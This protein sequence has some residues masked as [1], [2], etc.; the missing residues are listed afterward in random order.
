MKKNFINIL[1]SLLLAM[2]F[3]SSLAESSA[4]SASY[5]AFLPKFE[6]FPVDP[7][8][9]LATELAVSE[10]YE[11]PK[12]QCWRAVKNALLKANVI[13]DRP[14]TRY[15]KQA[16]KELEQK[17]GFRKLDIS[18]PRE[19][20]PHSILVYGGRGPGHVEIR[21][22]YGFVSDFFNTEPSP[23]PLLGVYIHQ[24]E[25]PRS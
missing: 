22:R 2:P 10:A 11:H 7:Q 25:F 19:A 20:P 15:A 4:H 21:T 17:F 23:R 3:F 18:D 6:I 14:T 8:M 16:G 13:S 12:N 24:A 5:F 9:F 1:F